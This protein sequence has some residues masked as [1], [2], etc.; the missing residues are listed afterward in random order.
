MTQTEIENDVDAEFSDSSIGGYL[1]SSSETFEERIK[2]LNVEQLEGLKDKMMDEAKVIA[3]KVKHIVHGTAQLSSRKPDE[4]VGEQ[5]TVMNVL[6][7]INQCKIRL[8]PVSP[9]QIS[10]KTSEKWMNETSQLFCSDVSHALPS[11]EWPLERTIYR[12]SR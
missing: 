5:E 8:V 4:V 2:R 6:S 9:S 10:I 7:P 1:Q 12:Q 11:H 3:G